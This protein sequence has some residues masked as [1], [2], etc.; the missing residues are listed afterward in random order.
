MRAWARVELEVISIVWTPG[1]AVVEAEIIPSAA[2]VG[3]GTLLGGGLGGGVV[4]QALQR[5]MEF[6]PCFTV[7]VMNLP[8]EVSGH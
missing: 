7:H 8:Q 5:I 3:V 2:E 6:V 4:D 1:A